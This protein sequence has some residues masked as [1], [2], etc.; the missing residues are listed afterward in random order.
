MIN[1]GTTSSAVGTPPTHHTANYGFPMPMIL[2]APFVPHFQ[3][4]VA[5]VK[6]KSPPPPLF[7]SQPLPHTP[8]PINLI[9]LHHPT[10]NLFLLITQ[11]SPTWQHSSSSH[12]LCFLLILNL[13][14]YSCI[15][16]KYIYHTSLFLSPLRNFQH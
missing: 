10:Y 12:H 3:R 15:S 7:S 11:V 1:C 16:S 5:F 6:M 9:I 8:F 13:L 4:L 14:H 2:E